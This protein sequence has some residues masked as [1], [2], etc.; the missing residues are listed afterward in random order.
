MN[1]KIRHREAAGQFRT[2]LAHTVKYKA[3]FH[4]KVIHE[5]QKHGRICNYASA[6]T[7]DD[8][9]WLQVVIVTQNAMHHLFV[10]CIVTVPVASL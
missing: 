5:G 3:P 2:V 9:L 4:I 7:H 1:N 10:R 6:K 8:S